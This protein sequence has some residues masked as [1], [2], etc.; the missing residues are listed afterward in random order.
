MVKCD[1]LIIQP[2]VAAQPASAAWSPAPASLCHSAQLR[3]SRMKH[4][5]KPA[6][7]ASEPTTNLAV[8]QG[9]VT[10]PVGIETVSGGYLEVYG[11]SGGPLN[12]RFKNA[13]NLSLIF[14]CTTSTTTSRSSWVVHLKSSPCQMSEK[15]NLKVICKLLHIFCWRKLHLAVS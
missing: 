3:G 1:L 14:L 2:P 15:S 13:N 6:L 8:V 10:F 11:L 12:S 9:M 4:L 7:F 5:C